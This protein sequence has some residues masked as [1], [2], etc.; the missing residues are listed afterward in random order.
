MRPLTG[1]RL[2]AGGPEGI[3]F[4]L[5]RGYR[6]TLFPLGPALARV[7]VE[8]PEGLRAPRTWSWLGRLRTAMRKWPWGQSQ[9]WA[10]WPAQPRW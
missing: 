2:V 8:R 9:H 6:L 1:A 5:D 4:A 10:K 3:V 7:L